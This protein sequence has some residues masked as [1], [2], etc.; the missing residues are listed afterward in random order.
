[1]PSPDS[2]LL[3]MDT[4]RILSDCPNDQ[5]S[6]ETHFS[7][8]MESLVGAVINETL[9]LYTVLPF[10]LKATVEDS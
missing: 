1:M 2:T 4:D 8:L 10:I 7:S 5:W 9:R 6:Y 3:Q